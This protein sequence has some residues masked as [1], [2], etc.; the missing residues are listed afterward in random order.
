MSHR[1]SSHGRDDLIPAYMTQTARVLTVERKKGKSWSYISFTIFGDAL[2]YPYTFVNVI[3]Y[4]CIV[5]FPW[6]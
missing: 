5:Y 2:K 4:R 3:E 6:K 1:G